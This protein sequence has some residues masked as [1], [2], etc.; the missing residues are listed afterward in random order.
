MMDGEKAGARE[1]GATEQRS[2]ISG[3]GLSAPE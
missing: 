1:A 2:D 3:T